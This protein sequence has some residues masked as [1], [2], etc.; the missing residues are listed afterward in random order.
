MVK[1]ADRE[2]RT[3]RA[4]KLED[5]VLVLTG[6]TSGIGLATARQAAR[7]GARIILV[8]RDEAALRTLAEELIQEGA[9]AAWVAADVAD[10]AALRRAADEAADRFGGFDTW[11]NNAGVSIYGA[12]TEVPL[13]DQRRLFDTNVWGVVVGSR[14]A[15]EHLR[16]RGGTIINIGSVLSDRALPLQGTYS[17]S[18][19]AVKGFTD[20][21]RMELERDGAPI[22]VTLIKPSAIDTPYTRHARNYLDAK[23]KNPPPVYDPELV[24]RA[25]L[26]A[27]EHRVRDLVVGGGG[28][29]ISLVGR[30]APRLMDRVMEWTMFEGQ[31]SDE[32]PD[33]SGD[34]LFSPPDEAPEERGDYEGHVRRHSLYTQIAKHPMAAATVALAVGA[35]LGAAWYA[36]D[37]DRRQEARRL[38]DQMLDS[39]RG[40]ARRVRRR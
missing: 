1:A 7:R 13:E 37:E 21:L 31:K 39:A 10:E 4:K 17:A 2:S 19:H 12:I 30:H 25:V 8:A 32:A 18:K 9:E 27:A 28:K 20:A 15:A 38:A 3:N 34:S 5:Q 29:L 26:Y 16:E 35:L 36:A 33:S 24:A 14:L 22:S 6:A 23:P 11:I 40:V